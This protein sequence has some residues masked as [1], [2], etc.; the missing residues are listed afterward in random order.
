MG[1]VLHSFFLNFLPNLVSFL[2][3][4]EG[5]SLDEANE[6]MEIIEKQKTAMENN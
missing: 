2:S 6:I 3:K 1:N 5:L 4:K